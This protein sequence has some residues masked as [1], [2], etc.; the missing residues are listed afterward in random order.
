MHQST[1]CSVDMCYMMGFMDIHDIKL[2]RFCFI[3]PRVQI[4]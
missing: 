4:L 1:I 2:T 3:T